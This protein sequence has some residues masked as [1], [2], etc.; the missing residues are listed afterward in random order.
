M[1]KSIIQ[2]WLVES[3]PMQMI[4]RSITTLGLPG[5]QKAA[6][7][8]YRDRGICLHPLAAWRTIIVAVTIGA[9]AT[10]FFADKP[11]EFIAAILAGG[12]LLV[13]YVEWMLG[14]RESSM[15]MFYERLE[16]ANEHR[17]NIVRIGMKMNR[18]ERYVFTE[19]DNLEYVIERYRFGYMSPSLARRGV[20]TFASR[21]GIIGFKTELRSIL[22]NGCAYSELT[23]DVVGKVMDD[24]DRIE[25]ARRAAAPAVPVT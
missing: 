20:N 23:C 24:H 21:L 14:R 17:S 22:A 25:A 13:T 10:A 7:E 2:R 12:A 3:P 16:T 18:T 4:L 8:L 19:I 1:H 5:D 15:D 6:R 9:A 11:A